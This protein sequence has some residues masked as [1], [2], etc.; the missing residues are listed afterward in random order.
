M[1]RFLVEKRHL[2]TKTHMLT[3]IAVDLNDADR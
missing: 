2:S 3:S 1:V